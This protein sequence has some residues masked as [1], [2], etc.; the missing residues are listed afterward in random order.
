MTVSI[1]GRIRRLQ[2][3]SEAL[4]DAQKRHAEKLIRFQI[5]FTEKDAYLFTKLKRRCI[6]E[7]K[8]MNSLIKQLIDEM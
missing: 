7:G 1:L 3:R 2:M 4:K 5:S 8:S 6:E